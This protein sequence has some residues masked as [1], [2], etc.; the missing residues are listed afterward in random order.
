M[1]D[2]GGG[3]GTDL[4]D[5]RKLVSLMGVRKLGKLTSFDGLGRGGVKGDSR[6]EACSAGRIGVQLPRTGLLLREKIEQTVSGSWRDWTLVGETTANI[7]SVPVMNQVRLK[8]LYLCKLMNTTTPV[9][10]HS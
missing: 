10:F 3:R 7:S 5:L 4:G 1:G 8:V 9:P 2:S 6:F